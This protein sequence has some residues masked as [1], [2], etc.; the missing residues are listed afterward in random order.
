MFQKINWNKQKFKQYNL[1]EFTVTRQQ[2]ILSREDKIISIM[3]ESIKDSETRGYQMKSNKERK[4]LRAIAYT[5]PLTAWV[6]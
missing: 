1:G 2:P 3:N 5:V 6:N 4:L